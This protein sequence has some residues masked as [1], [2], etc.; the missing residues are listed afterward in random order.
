MGNYQ[1]TAVVTGGAAGI[2]KRISE[3]LAAAGYAVAIFDRDGRTAETLARELERNGFSAKGLRCDVSSPDDIEKAFDAVILDY[4]RI[5]V[6]A[7]NAGVGGYLPWLEADRASLE[8]MLSVNCT[9]AFL[10]VQRAAKEM[11]RFGT[12]GK[13]ILTLSQASYTQDEGDVIPY[14]M[15]KWGERGLMRSAAAALSQYG[16]S[17]NGVCPGTVWT[18]MMEGFCKEYIGAGRGTREEFIGFIES[19]YPMGRMQTADDIADM[20]MFLIEKSQNISG[21]AIL[22]SG[23]IAFS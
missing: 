8:K 14:C 9:G 5:D 20:Y 11:I 16:I 21:Q 13:I 2:G 22:V 7:N 18:P 1:K 19:K 6:L 12:K 10:C 17:V 23:G 3:K 15:S 4:G